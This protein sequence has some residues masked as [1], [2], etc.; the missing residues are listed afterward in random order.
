M[1]AR[2][3]GSIRLWQTELFVVVIVV[4]ILILSGSLSAGLKDTLTHMTETNE[5]RN[6][7]ALAQRLELELPL[8]VEG[9]AKVRSVVADYRNIYGGGIWVY[10]TEGELLDSEFDTSPSPAVL[11]SALLQALN[12]DASYV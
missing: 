3:R 8:G 6:A 12:K 11:E 4:A 7:S 5:L 1:P 10:D 9:T 2:R